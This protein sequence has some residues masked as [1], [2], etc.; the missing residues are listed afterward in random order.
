MKV[1]Y[2]RLSLSVILLNAFVEWKLAKGNLIL[3]FLVESLTL[4][5]YL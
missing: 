2:V 3:I 1:V 4:F 5:E